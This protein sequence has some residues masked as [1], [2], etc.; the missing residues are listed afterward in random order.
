MQ[1]IDQLVVADRRRRCGTSYISVNSVMGTNPVGHVSS[2]DD[3]DT[4][5]QEKQ[6][7]SH[8]LC[9]RS[10]RFFSAT[11]LRSHFQLQLFQLL[12]VPD[13]QQWLARRAQQ[14]EKLT[15]IGARVHICSVCQKCDRPAAADG[16]KQSDPEFFVQS[17]EEQPYFRDRQAV[18]AQVREYD[19]LEEI[20]GRIPPLR[21][22]TRFGAM[23]RDRRLDQFSRIPPLKLAC[24]KAGNGRDLAR[25][26]VLFQIRAHG[27]SSGCRFAIGHG[28][29]VEVFLGDAAFVV[30][31]VE[32][33]HPAI[34]DHDVRMMVRGFRVGH[35]PVDERDGGRGNR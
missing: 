4:T 5:E 33:R 6:S 28:R 20:N 3:D 1:A 30:R 18:S 13:D 15:V 24:R 17:F 19:E 16:I 35:Q 11:R 26:V 23:R 7:T 21:E 31:A 8:L 10:L 29:A 22:S 14:I 2:N 25:A 12:F 32:Q 9:N 34:V 27:G